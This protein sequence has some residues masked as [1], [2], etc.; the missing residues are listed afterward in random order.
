MS[1]LKNVR[2]K[3]ASIDASSV[4]SSYNPDNLRIN[5]AYESMYNNKYMELMQ[6]TY[7]YDLSKLE[8]RIKMLNEIP[9]KLN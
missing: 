9:D 4:P 3:H 7:M 5:Q 1:Y 8:K 2:K 6:P